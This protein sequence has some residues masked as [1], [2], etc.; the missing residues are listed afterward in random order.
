LLE[1]ARPQGDLRSSD[2][3]AFLLYGERCGSTDITR[4]EAS[5]KSC[6]GLRGL[7][8]AR[9]ETLIE[10][11]FD[12]AARARLN[13]LSETCRQW[14]EEIPAARRAFLCGRDFYDHYHLRLRDL[15]KEVF[16]VV[17]LDNKNR[18]IH[19]DFISEGSL[20]ETLVHPR[21]VFANA[22]SRRAAAVAMVHNHPSGDPDP[23]PADKSMTKRL[24]SVADLVGIRLLD[25]VVIGDGSFISFMENGFLSSRH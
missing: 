11:G 16:I 10:L 19:E 9:P 24:Q 22:I 14:A 23:S 21:E 6:N 17:L 12:D 2:R 1:T 4:I 25:H 7:F 8:L 5:L 15:R 20:T 3:V 18:L 13:A